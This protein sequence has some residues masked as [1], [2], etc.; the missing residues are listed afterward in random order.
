MKRWSREQGFLLRED[1]D[2]TASIMPTAQYIRRRGLLA[3]PFARLL[4]FLGVV[5]PALLALIDTCIAQPEAASTLG[6]Y[7]IL[8]LEKKRLDGRE[9]GA[10]DLHQG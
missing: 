6:T 10:I 7:R 5:P 1:Q 9:A 3:L 4:V 2:I 8:V